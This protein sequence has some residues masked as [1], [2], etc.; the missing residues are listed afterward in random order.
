L[1]LIKPHERI[2]AVAVLSQDNIATDLGISQ[3]S[4]AR[5]GKY[6]DRISVKRL[7]NIATILKTTVSEL[8]NEKVSEI[9]NE[10]NNENQQAYLDKIS[11]ADQ[12]HIQTLK[13]EISFLH[14]LLEQS[15]DKNNES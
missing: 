11:Q 7:I 14:Q 9:I 5:L 3:P 6:D 10:Q 2:R 1:V 15:N 8:M 13:C 12:D 4:Y